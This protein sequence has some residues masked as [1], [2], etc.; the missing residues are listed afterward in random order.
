M[1]VAPHGLLGQS[2]DGDSIAVDG[3]TDDYH[4]RRAML[5]TTA[6]AEGAIEGV[7]SDYRLASPFATAFKFSRFDATAPV[8]PRNVSALTGRKRRRGSRA[9]A[10]RSSERGGG[11]ALVPAPR[12]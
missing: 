4:Q 12:G 1:Q 3:A 2:W 5:K 10:A 6:Q 11:A 9:D 7:A 8:P